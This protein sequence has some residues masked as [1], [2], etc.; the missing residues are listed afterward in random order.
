MLQLILEA[1]RGEVIHLLDGK[2]T[3]R[4]D[5]GGGGSGGRA[6]CHCRRVMRMRSEALSA[7][8]S[9]TGIDDR[10]ELRLSFSAQV[11]DTIERENQATS[12]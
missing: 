10:C 2:R 4:T 12:S 1:L 11:L 3:T 5:T 6:E 9:H 8:E 7:V